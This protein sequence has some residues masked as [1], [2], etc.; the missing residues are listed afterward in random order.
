MTT[1]MCL[2]M[3]LCLCPC[4]SLCLRL[5]VGRD[6]RLSVSVSMSVSM[7]VP[8]YVQRANLAM[9]GQPVRGGRGRGGGQWGAVRGAG[10]GD[11]HC[12]KCKVRR[13]YISYIYI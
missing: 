4:V 13:A 6:R 2:C 9:R 8:M 12:P 7:S 1:E 3:C 10:D 5:C 11:W